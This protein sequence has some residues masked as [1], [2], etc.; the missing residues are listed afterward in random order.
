MKLCNDL[1]KGKGEWFFLL[2]VAK[3]DLLFS[4]LKHYSLQ[5][6]AMAWKPLIITAILK[7]QRNMETT[8]TRETFFMKI[9]PGTSNVLKQR[10]SWK[11]SFNNLNL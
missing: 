1:N 2:R 3:M 6:S 9:F 5:T 11:L 4:N 7:M 8:L 10:H